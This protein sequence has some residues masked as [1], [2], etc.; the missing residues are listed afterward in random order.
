M[1]SDPLSACASINGRAIDDPT[2]ETLQKIIDG[3]I[4]LVSSPPEMARQASETA[5]DDVLAYLQR[6]IGRFIEKD[7]AIAKIILEQT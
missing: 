7:K 5:R 2:D 6:N 3:E 4:C 1:A